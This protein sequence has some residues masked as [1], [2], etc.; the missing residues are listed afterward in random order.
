MTWL[1]CIS[2]HFNTASL[3]CHATRCRCRPK[4]INRQIIDDNA[5]TTVFEQSKVAVG[6]ISRGKRSGYLPFASRKFQ[7]GLLPGAK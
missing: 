5:I 3:C 4:F 2:C 1:T 6:I 7:L